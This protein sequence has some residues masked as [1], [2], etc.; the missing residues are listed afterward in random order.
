MEENIVDNSI[1]S[2]WDAEDKIFSLCMLE[3]E[4]FTQYITKMDD[5]EELYHEKLL[6]NTFKGLNLDSVRQRKNGDLVN[7]EHHSS[8]NLPLLRRDYGYAI[9]LH[10]HSGR[11]VWPFIFNTGD[12]PKITVDYMNPTMF[13]NPIWVNTVEIEAS[14]K[15][16]NVK[17]KLC[18]NEAINVYDVLDLIWMPKFRNDRSVE[19]VI[20]ELVELYGELIV[21][22]KLLNVLRRSLILWAGKYITD[23]NQLKKVERCLNMSALEIG[24]IYDDIRA[25]RISGELMREHERGIEEGVEKGIE[26]GIEK[27]VEKGRTEGIEEGERRLILKFLEHMSPEEISSIT[28]VDLERILEIEKSG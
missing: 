6:S 23:E 8:I 27:G 11:N 19:E 13:F 14:Q 10:I 1:P 24:S 18:N 16:N 5:I 15:L 12:I 17:Y 9:S 26:K 20:L 7:T 3:I 4:K 22:E 21:D 28:D 2:I 25:A